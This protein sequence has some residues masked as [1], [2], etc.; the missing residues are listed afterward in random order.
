L[1]P[2]ESKRVQQK[3][4]HDL[5]QR[6]IQKHK[7]HFERA[8]AEINAGQKRS[9]WSWY[10]LPVAPFIVNGVERGSSTNKHYA[11]RTDEQVVAYL[12]LEAGGINLR[13]NYLA[14]LNAI[15]AQLE[16]GISFLRLMGD[17]DEPKARS[18]F[19]LFERIAAEMGDAELSRACKRVIYLVEAPADPPA[20]AAVAAGPVQ[21]QQEVS[22]D[23]QFIGASHY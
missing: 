7:T 17:L 10:I 20:P 15:A 3:D 2:E 5:Y 9:C 4:P 13:R 6:F 19:A 11:L 12:R 22:L 16:K 18:S 21:S 8:L 1:C 14:M 23:S